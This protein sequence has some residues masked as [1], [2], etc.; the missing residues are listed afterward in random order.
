[1][2]GCPLLCLPDCTGK[3]QLPQCGG[4]KMDQG[5]NGYIVAALN[6]STSVTM[7]PEVHLASDLP[8]PSPGEAD[9]H[10]NVGCLDQT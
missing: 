10:K 5:N 1:M 8:A 3:L 7:P 4:S 2:N 9:E 6:L